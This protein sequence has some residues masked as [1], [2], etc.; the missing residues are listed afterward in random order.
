M[1]N[2]KQT[3]LSKTS[4]KSNKEHVILP[5]HEALSQ[6][7]FNNSQLSFD[8]V[9]LTNVEQ[10]NFDAAELTDT[11]ASNHGLRYIHGSYDL[12]SSHTSSPIVNSNNRKKSDVFLKSGM[13][14]LQSLASSGSLYSPTS[15]AICIERYSKGDEIAWSFNERCHHAFHLDCI[16]DW[17]MEHDDC[18]LCR[19]E[20]LKSDDVSC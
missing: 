11:S 1:C 18:P 20:F 5:H 9:D 13:S 2:I 10:Q 4:G 17:L 14:Q 8:I 16:V 6:R 3:V 12:S 7:E 15:C 19:Q